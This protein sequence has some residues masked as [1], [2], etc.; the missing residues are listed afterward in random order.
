MESNL[1]LFQIMLDSGI[2]VKLVLLL[3]VGASVLSWSIIF[4]KRKE[5]MSIASSNKLFLNT[6][7]G[8]DDLK[9]ISNA[10]NNNPK[11]NLG[12]MYMYCYKELS[13]ISEKVDDVRQHFLSYGFTSLERSL[14]HALND[15]Q[16]EMGRSLSILASVGSISP[17]I[18]LFGTVWGIIDSF[19]GLASGGASLESV[20]PG[21]AEALVATAVGLA[22]AIPAVW[23]FNNFNNQV[24]RFTAEM[25]SF[26]HEFLNL[27]ERTIAGKK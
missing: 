8:T 19:T 12:I 4:K 23:F 18:G 22:A 17:F 16:S 20:A 6:Y 27:I 3:L 9:K 25:E 21:I 26:E 5:F 2:V 1:D 15:C 11:S 7:K 10:S 13:K 14:K 24:S